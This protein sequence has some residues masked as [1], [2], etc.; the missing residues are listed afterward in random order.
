MNIGRFFDRYYTPRKKK[1]N[2]AAAWIIGAIAFIALVPMAAKCDRKKGEW[3]IASLL[4]FVG[5]K[6]SSKREGKKEVTIALPGF[7]YVKSMTSELI[8]KKRSR[9]SEIA[10]DAGD[11]VEDFADDIADGIED[12]LEED[13][14]VDPEV[15]ITEE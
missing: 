10:E 3:G 5:C 11:A 14:I 15:V 6:R 7:P 13:G 1:K 8:N 2:H 9:I 4:I 12:L